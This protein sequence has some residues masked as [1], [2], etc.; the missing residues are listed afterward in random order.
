MCT[1]PVLFDVTF[2][3]VHT[4]SALV[5]YLGT[6]F[7]TGGK[8]VFLHPYLIQNTGAEMRFFLFLFL[9]LPS[10]FHLSE[11]NRFVTV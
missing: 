6:R 8:K 9:T 3:I 4:S 1:L 7:A 11:V 2:P 5:E 10:Q